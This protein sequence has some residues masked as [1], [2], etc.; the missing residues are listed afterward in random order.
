M[1]KA[2][3]VAKYI[4]D[5]YKKRSKCI[6]DEMKLHKLLYLSQRESLAV[7]NK[8]MFNECFEGWKYGPVCPAVRSKFS[9][10]DGIVVKTGKISDESAYIVNNVIEQY[11]SYESWALSEL[12]HKEVSWLNSRK[13]LKSGE[14]GDNVIS[15]DDIAE[16]AKKV[17]PYDSLW[18]MYYDEFEDG[19]PD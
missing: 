16:D 18:D 11:G 19:E 1:E 13:G 2:L 6:I 17:R 10:E 8:P 3:D 9:S 5:M 4:F 7:L 12:T 15:I 14:N